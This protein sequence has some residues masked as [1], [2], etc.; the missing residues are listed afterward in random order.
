MAEVEVGTVEDRR[1]HSLA[2]IASVNWSVVAVPPRSRVTV[3]PSRIVSSSALR[4]RWA[5]GSSVRYSS[6]MHA[7]SMSAPGLAI[8]LP[9]MSGAVPCT[10]S[11]I[12]PPRPMFAPGASPSPPTSPEIRSDVT[13]EIRR[14]DDV[15]PLRMEHQVHRHRVDDH[16][17]ELDVRV[18][19]R[20]HPSHI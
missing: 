20:D 6:I 17:L 18:L 7:A 15:V 5:R 2:M 9:A 11:K 19:A 1:R 8:P 16:F 10:A 4:M 3:F 14:D 12:A 13:E